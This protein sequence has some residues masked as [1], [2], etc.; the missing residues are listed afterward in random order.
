MNKIPHS[1]SAEVVAEHARAASLCACLAPRVEEI[2][3]P[4]PSIDS[5]QPGEDIRGCFPRGTLQVLDSCE[6]GLESVSQLRGEVHEAPVS[7]LAAPKLQAQLACLKVNL[8]LSQ[9]QHLALDSP[10]VGIGDLYR[11]RQVGGQ[12]PHDRLELSRFKETGS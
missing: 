8:A 9:R 6:L 11:K 1:R 5:R 3:N 7:I 2:L 10:P 12:S 4:P